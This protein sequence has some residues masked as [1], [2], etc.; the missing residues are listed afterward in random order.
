MS[1][2]QNTV[3]RIARLARIAVTQE[4]LAPLA[5][6]LSGILAWVEQLNGLD[7]TGVE[8]MTSAVAMSLKSREDV[9]TSGNLQAEVTRNAPLSEDGFFVVPKVVE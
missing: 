5:G 9:I 3:R 6:E 4:E 7:T 8:P 1:V 2:D